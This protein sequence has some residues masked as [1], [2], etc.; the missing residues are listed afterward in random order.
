VFRYIVYLVNL[1]ETYL[2][3]YKPRFKDKTY[4]LVG[5]SR[6]SIYRLLSLK[7]LKETIA[8]NIVFNKYTFLA[9]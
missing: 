8:T 2:K 7:N 3:K 1:K 6:S 4:I 5:I 9:S